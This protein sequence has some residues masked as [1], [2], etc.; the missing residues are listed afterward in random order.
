MSRDDTKRNAPTKFRDFRQTSHGGITGYQFV[1]FISQWDFNEFAKECQRTSKV[2][3]LKYW[4]EEMYGGKKIDSHSNII[5][6]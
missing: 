4:A 1:F 6:R 2:T 3:P 5:F